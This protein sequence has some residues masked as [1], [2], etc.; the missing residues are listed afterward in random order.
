MVFHFLFCK[1]SRIMRLVLY[2]FEQ[3]LDME[4]RFIFRFDSGIHIYGGN[5]TQQLLA[6]YITMRTNAFTLGTWN[7]HAC[8]S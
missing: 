5:N 1:N 6:V 7:R 8:N 2:L 4:K 3:L